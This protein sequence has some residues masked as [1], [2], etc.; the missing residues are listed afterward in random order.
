MNRTIFGV[1][2]AVVAG[3]LCGPVGCQTQIRPQGQ[4][5]IEA[6]FNGFELKADLPAGT[7]VEAVVSAAE[8]GFRDRGYSVD[9][10]TATEDRG[11]VVA[12]PPSTRDFPLVRVTARRFDTHTRVVVKK[13]PFSNDEGLCRGV[14]ERTLE[15]LG[16]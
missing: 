15:R 9:R 13:E 1:T 14:L 8:A 16:L 2:G 5:G 12:R 4:T 6:S 7:A 10:A 11:E 3:V